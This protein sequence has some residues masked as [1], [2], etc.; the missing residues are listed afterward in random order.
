MIRSM[1]NKMTAKLEAYAGPPGEAEPVDI[2][3]VFRCTVSD[4]IWMYALGYDACYLDHKDFKP[5]L[6]LDVLTLAWVVPLLRQFPFLPKLRY[7]TN[8]AIVGWL[9]PKAAPILAWRRAVGALVQRV[10]KEVDQARLTGDAKAYM[11]YPTVFHEILYANELPPEEKAIPRMIEEA[12]SLVGA[13]SVSTAWAVSL[14]VAHLFLPE[15]ALVLNKII[16]EITVLMPNSDDEV[17]SVATLENNAPYLSAAI[18]EGLRMAL[19]TGQRL[20]RV[21]PEETLRYT[22]KDTGEAVLFPPG[23]VMSMTA[24][25][26]NYNEDN[27][28]HPFSFRPE[29]WLD[30]RGKRRKE[31]ERY[32]LTFG[33]GTRNCVG[34]K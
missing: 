10:N 7:L 34:M 26:V 4:V 32:I 29:R 24:L 11:E 25:A 20:A 31:L 13:G 19:G 33:K 2:A 16:A 5:S 27:F 3:N 23:V 1:S 18:S 12:E 22:R 8:D 17:P 15:S 6:A 30:E 9:V 14:T 21:A 28:P